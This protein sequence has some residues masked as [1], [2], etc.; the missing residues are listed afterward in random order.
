MKPTYE[1]AKKA[2]QVL[3]DYIAEDL[4]YVHKDSYKQET[5]L[6]IALT[7]DCFLD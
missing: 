2:K 5:L 1:E 3:M 7:Q 4:N 6:Y